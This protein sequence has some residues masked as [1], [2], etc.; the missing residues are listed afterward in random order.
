[1]TQIFIFEIIREIT[2]VIKTQIFMYFSWFEKSPSH[3]RGVQENEIVWNV[4]KQMDKALHLNKRLECKVTKK[5][6]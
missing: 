4:S 3:E 5:I 1:M 2:R 6:L